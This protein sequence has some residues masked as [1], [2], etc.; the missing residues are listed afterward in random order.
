MN[1]K[2]EGKSVSVEAWSLLIDYRGMMIFMETSNSKDRHA[3][4]DNEELTM[5]CTNVNES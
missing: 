1:Y 4:P 2:T 3:E 5:Q